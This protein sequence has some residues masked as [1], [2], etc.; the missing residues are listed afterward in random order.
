MGG[1]EAADVAG[2]QRV[3]YKWRDDCDRRVLKQV[4]GI[5][6]APGPFKGALRACIRNAD[7]VEQKQHGDGREEPGEAR[8]ESVDAK[9][10]AGGARIV[11]R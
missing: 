8:V 6:A 10:G 2:E 7:P 3:V 4:D 11:E 1:N 9:V 5:R